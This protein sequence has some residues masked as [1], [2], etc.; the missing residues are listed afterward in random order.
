MQTGGKNKNTPGCTHYLQLITQQVNN[1]PKLEVGDSF[2][3]FER[4]KARHGKLNDKNIKFR[5]TRQ[6]GRWLE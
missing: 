6:W 3:E 1:E 2:N 4:V 5:H